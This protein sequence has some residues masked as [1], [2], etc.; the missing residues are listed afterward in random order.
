MFGTIPRKIYEMF[1]E[2]CW[3][4]FRAY[5]K[6]VNNRTRGANNEYRGGFCG[7]GTGFC[8]P[9]GGF[10]VLVDVVACHYVY[11]L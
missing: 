7:P 6:T 4:N 1:E 9:G 11:Y 10:L 5:S 8:V 3:I 2:I